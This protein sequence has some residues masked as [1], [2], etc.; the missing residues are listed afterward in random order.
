M[1]PTKVR[2]VWSAWQ[3]TTEALKGLSVAL[4]ELVRP[5]TPIKN[6]Y[7]EWWPQNED[8]LR[9]L[10]L[11]IIKLIKAKDTTP[12]GMVHRIPD[13][14][15][16]LPLEMRD[17]GVRMLREYLY[18]ILIPLANKEYWVAHPQPNHPLNLE[19]QPGKRVSVNIV[20]HKD[21]GDIYHGVYMWEYA[22]KEDLVAW[23]DWLNKGS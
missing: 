15:Y 20:T 3:R 6:S 7:S 2:K 11:A 5:E 17:L 10:I 1:Q 12:Y 13:D 23:E 22:L 16:W 9:K 19:S 8:E 4:L 14:I 18:E 21:C